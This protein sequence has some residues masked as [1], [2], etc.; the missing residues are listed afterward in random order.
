MKTRSFRIYSSVSEFNFSGLH[1][2]H[3]TEVTVIPDIVPTVKNIRSLVRS[4]FPEY[5]IDETDMTLSERIHS[6]LDIGMIS[7][8]FKMPDEFISRSCVLMEV[9]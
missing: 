7:V 8:P 1:S 3:M 5:E 2:T 9:F 6:D 4:L